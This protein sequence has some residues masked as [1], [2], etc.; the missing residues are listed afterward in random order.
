VLI[1][2][3]SWALL[4]I[5]AAI[6]T[7]L[8]G[9]ASPASE[10]DVT[11][12]L[13]SDRTEVGT[14]HNTSRT[15]EILPLTGVRIIAA[16]W[17]V[18]FHIRGNLELEFPELGRLLDPIL[19]HGDLGVDLFFALSGFVLT[20]NYVDRMGERL[21]R[22]GITK[23]VW[24][25]LARVWPVYFVTL[26]IAMLWHGWLMAR[27]G[28][29]PVKPEDFSA[30]SYLRQVFMVVMWNEPD[31]DRVTW[32]G[33][34]WSISC[35]WLVYLLF[36]FIALL[37]LR[38]TWVLRIRHLVVLGIIALLPA[39]MLALVSGTLYW[40][41]LWVLRLLGSFVA[42]G[43]ACLLARR[44]AKTKRNDT[45]ATWCSA[46]FTVGVVA[47]LY[48][49]WA[50]D[51][52]RY[53]VLAAFLFTPLLIA[54]AISDRGLSRVL[55][56]R[57]FV[58]GGYFSYSLYLVH[59]LVIE[60]IWWVQTQWP[61]ALPPHTLATKI[62][63]LSVPIVACLAAYVMWRWVEEPARITMRAMTKS[64]MR[65]SPQLG[66]VAQPADVET[67]RPVHEPA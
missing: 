12:T 9:T 61:H 1:V 32:N 46:G 63:F 37:L 62:V 45:I 10:L 33:P 18:L 58:V 55:S 39:V 17:V 43:I 6:K 22:R 56:T 19:S 23:F 44:I 3:L 14:S 15:G 30:L 25:R 24:A 42:G 49:S 53:Y 16:L 20:L 2:R 47:I 4:A 54:L 7:G 52:P 64:P 41:Y 13:V 59:M 65:P 51:H 35:E 26:N 28:P 66:N 48:L 36:P 67:P 38:L 31:S 50:T 27:G 60:P 29:D 8:T 40:P 21:S 57:A 34:A 11:V 5:A